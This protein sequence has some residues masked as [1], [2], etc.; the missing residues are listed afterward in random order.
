MTFL[1]DVPGKL[2]YGVSLFILLIKPNTYYMT[3]IVLGAERFIIQEEKNNL[4]L[5]GPVFS[6]VYNPIEGSLMICFN[7]HLFSDVYVISRSPAP[8]GKQH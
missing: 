3:G 6:T 7:S 4:V 5:M 1:Q 2:M 8:H